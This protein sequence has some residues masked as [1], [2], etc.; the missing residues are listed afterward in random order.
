M[1]N[2]F[3]PSLNRVLDDNGNPISGAKMNFYATGS[4]TAATW[5]TDQA[6]TTPGTN[7]LVADSTGK[8]APAY[9]DPDTTYRVK[10]TDSTGATTIFDVDPV[11]GYD[12]GAVQTAATEAF[13]S[14]T[15]AAA[16]AVAAAASETAAL[17]SAND[18][19]EAAGQAVAASTAGEYGPYSNTYATAL[20]QGVT[21]IAIGGAGSGFTDGTYAGGVSGGPTGFAFTYTCSGGGVTSTTITNPGLAS[22]GA[23]P[24]LSFPSGGGTGASATATVGSLIPNQGAYWA[25]LSD[26]KTL[27][28]F[29][30]NGGSVAAIN[31]ANGTTQITLAQKAALDDAQAAL[32]GTFAPEATSV[33]ANVLA[34]TGKIVLWSANDHRYRLRTFSRQASFTQ[35]AVF[36]DDLPFPDE[37]GTFTI[38]SPD[39]SSSG[40]NLPDRVLFTPTDPLSTLPSGDP[41]GANFSGLQGYIE[42]S[43]ANKAALAALANQAIQP[44]N[45]TEGGINPDN[46]YTTYSVP[47]KPRDTR[48]WDYRTQIDVGAT[49]TFTT[50]GAAVRSL[51]NATDTASFTSNPLRVDVQPTSLIATPLNPIAIIIDPGTYQD[52]NLHL[53]DW[54]S[55]VARYPNTVFFEHSSGATRPIVQAHLNHQLV[56]INWKSTVAE[57]TDY[58]TNPTTSSA[59][60]AVHRDYFHLFQT[61]DAEDDY[62]RCAKLQIIGGSMTVGPLAGIQALGIGMPVGDTVE[63]FDLDLDCDNASYANALVA[64]N[65]SSNTYGGGRFIIRNCRDIS[66]RA[67]NAPT[68]GVQ[69]KQ[70]NTYPN[71][72]IIDNCKN[73]H[74]I[75]LSGT[76]AGNWLL[77]G[78][79]TGSITDTIPGGDSGFSDY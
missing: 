13:A 19:E 48:L 75:A 39:Y 66:G 54:V 35:W 50:P 45:Y 21:A 8:L 31:N 69:V 53:P 51:Y 52:V 6:G 2:L 43:A 32:N 10:L 44:A 55:L 61:Q 49:R 11:R 33:N 3:Q 36:D 64:A 67:T 77:R 16:S 72:L 34:C 18:A 41:D 79:W 17:I 4:T 28:L 46:I 58:A 78:N 74:T 27:G 65:N 70:D 73:F 25:A 62:Q 63:L 29:R 76:T 24:T 26:N 71:E 37:V 38:S 1:A 14:E 23:A 22:T 47:A 60:Y 9:L 5:F 40:V 12:Q 30:N 56:D 20:P 59:R 15:A 42:L 68:V 57:G 7:P